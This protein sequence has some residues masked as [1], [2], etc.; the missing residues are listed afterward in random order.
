MRD[1][2]YLPVGNLDGCARR[3]LIA[4]GLIVVCA[5]PAIAG[6]DTDVSEGAVIFQQQCVTCHTVAPGA[7]GMMA[8][9]LRGLLGRKAGSTEFGYS[10]ALKNSQIV[11]SAK[12]LDKFLMAPSKLVPGT[13]MPV[14]ISDRD[15]RRKVIAYLLSLD[16]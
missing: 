10:A 2:L 5:S 16:K 8:P 11:W 7:S 6:P 3:L 9:N 13:R 15:I 14:S 4:L 12:T 1:R